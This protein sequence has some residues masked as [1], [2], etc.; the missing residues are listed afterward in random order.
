[1]QDIHQLLNHADGIEI[2]NHLKN[3]A[4]SPAELLDTVIE[5]A[6]KVNPQLNAINELNHE[7][8]VQSLENIDLNASALAGVPSFCKGLFTLSKGLRM[9]NGTRALGNDIAEIDDNFI[10]RYKAG[11]IVIAGSTNSPE[12]GT[13]FTTESSRHGAARSPWNLAHSSG[14]SSGGASAIVAARVVPFAHATDGGGSIRVPAS[15]C[16]LFGLKPSRGLMPIGPYVGEGWA[17]FG[18]PHA[19][20]LSVRDSAALLDIS[21]GTDLGAPYSAPPQPA[22]YVAELD[23]PLKKLKIGLYESVDRWATSEDV[24]KAVQFAAKCCEDLGHDVEITRIPVD[25]ELFFNDFFNIM[26]VNTADYVGHIGQ[27]QGKPVDLS[28]L[29]PR[30]R[31]FVEAKKDT[32]AIEYVNSVTNMHILG[33]TMAEYMK[34]FDV[35]LSPTLAREPIKIGEFNFDASKSLEDI[36]DAFHAYAPFTTV[37]NATGQPAMNVPLFWNDA[38]LPIGV[39]FAGRFGEEVTLLQLA[40][41]LE[42]AVPWI[43]KIPPV[44]AI[45]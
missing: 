27:M 14:G 35:I 12:F 23:K 18:T 3:K 8:A 19:V 39:Q 32:S 13:S 26:A 24:K 43:D 34:D 10:T 41:Q 45:F 33:R 36:S 42:Q 17:G 40:R 4:F 44:N 29:D 25:Y 38:G 20:S 31:T 30:N 21:A 5:R 2:A 37:A 7:V 1:M 16:G 28:L 9:T 15:C 6:E 11:G 22:S